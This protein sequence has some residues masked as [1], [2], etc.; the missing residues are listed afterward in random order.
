M[1]RQ[2]LNLQR[3]LQTSII[4][5]TD[6]VKLEISIK[7]REYELKNIITESKNHRSKY[8]DRLF[9]MYKDRDEKTKTKRIK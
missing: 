1:D 2:I 4:V 8:M 9:L 6:P 7:Q 5:P 3:E